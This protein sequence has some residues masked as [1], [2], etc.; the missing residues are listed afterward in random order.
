MTKCK[1]L[2]ELKIHFAHSELLNDDFG[3]MLDNSLVKSIYQLRR[4]YRLDSMLEIF[5]LGKLRTVRLQGPH[6]GTLGYTA[7]EAM[8]EWMK[9]EFVVRANMHAQLTGSRDKSIKV[10]EVVIN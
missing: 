8:A 5:H 4:H 3:N 10:L 2:R 9:W 1:D 7:L 6:K